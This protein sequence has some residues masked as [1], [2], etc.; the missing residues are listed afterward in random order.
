MVSEELK[1][2]TRETF[3][4]RC[5]KFHPLS[6]FTIGE[7]LDRRN[8]R[9]E[10]VLQ[11]KLARRVNQAFN[12][13]KQP[14]K[15]KYNPDG[16]L[17][18]KEWRDLRTYLRKIEKVY[19]VTEE[20]FNKMFLDQRGCCKIC[21]VHQKDLNYRL[22]IDHNHDTKEVRALLCYGCNHGIGNFKED[23]NKMQKAINY[24]KEYNNV[25]K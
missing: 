21:G 4:K 22:N 2:L 13:K 18:H 25:I 17:T 14:L 3:C 16:E 15:N 23:I 1:D 19:G 8:G 5:N 6:D 10:L 11:C 7:R 9:E 12:K 24:L 20:R